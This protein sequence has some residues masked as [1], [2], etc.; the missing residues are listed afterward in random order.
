LVAKIRFLQ[1]LLP[2]NLAEAAVLF[3][4]DIIRLGD[5]HISNAEVK[6]GSVL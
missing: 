3:G 4:M 5:F 2:T 1:P 6:P